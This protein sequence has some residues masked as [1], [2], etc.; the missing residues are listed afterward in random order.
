VFWGQAIGF[1]SD[2]SMVVV[3]A[4]RADMGRRVTVEIVS[5]IPSAGGKMVFARMAGS[6][7]Y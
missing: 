4:G 5:V 2:G 7:G 6:N 3:T 1:L